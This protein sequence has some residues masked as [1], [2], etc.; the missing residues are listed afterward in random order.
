MIESWPIMWN[1]DSGTQIFMSA[2]HD[3]EP[4]SVPVPNSTAYNVYFV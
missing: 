3:D 2:D 4:P 1:I